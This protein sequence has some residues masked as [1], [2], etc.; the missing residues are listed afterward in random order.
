[1]AR[2]QV[3]R[4]LERARSNLAALMEGKDGFVG[5]G[6]GRDAAGR[7]ILHVLVSSAGCGAWAACPDVHEGCPVTVQISGA[8][9]RQKG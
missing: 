7:W 3:P 2:G 4:R 9:K 8:P 1:M 6:I 5:V